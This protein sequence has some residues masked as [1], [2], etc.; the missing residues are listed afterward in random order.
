MLLLAFVAAARCL[1]FARGR[2]ST[3]SD[4]PVVGGGHIGE[5]G[6]DGSMT[7]LA[8]AC[9]RDEERE[10]EGSDRSSVRE[11]GEGSPGNGET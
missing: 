2:T 8:G 6:E 11:Q 5:G 3:S 10:G 1:A 9:G 4:A 7:V